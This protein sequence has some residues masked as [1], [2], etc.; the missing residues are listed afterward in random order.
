MRLFQIILVNNLIPTWRLKNKVT[1]PDSGILVG[2]INHVTHTA[3]NGL[4]GLI[5]LFLLFGSELGGTIGQLKLNVF[6]IYLFFLNAEGK[7]HA[8]GN[9]RQLWV[10]FGLRG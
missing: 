5:T 6:I 9:E 1:L 3:L 2:M 7:S 4:Y 8:R 10:F